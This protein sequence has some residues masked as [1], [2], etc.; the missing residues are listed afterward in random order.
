[1]RSRGQAACWACSYLNNGQSRAA[2]PG[3]ELTE[4]SSFCGLRGESK[5]QGILGLMLLRQILNK[6]DC[7]RNANSVPIGARLVQGGTEQCPSGEAEPQPLVLAS[8]TC[9]R[10]RAFTQVIMRRILR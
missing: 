5:R 4:G 6:C 3:T 10:T 2:R 8:G 9:S 7:V 1:M